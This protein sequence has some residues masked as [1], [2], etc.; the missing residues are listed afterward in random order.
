VSFFPSDFSLF[1]RT[2]LFKSSIFISALLEE[3]KPNVISIVP[4]VMARK[5][6]DDVMPCTEPP[7][8]ILTLPNITTN[9][10]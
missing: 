6:G 10:D 8:R 2:N 4:F 5:E 1:I 9:K 3:E 7:I